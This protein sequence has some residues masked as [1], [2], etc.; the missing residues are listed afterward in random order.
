[1]KK[2]NEKIN[3]KKQKLGKLKKKIIL[4]KKQKKQKKKKKKKMRKNHCGLLL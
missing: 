4:K 1:L 2:T 3:E